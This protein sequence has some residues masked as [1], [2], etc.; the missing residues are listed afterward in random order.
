M[1]QCEYCTGAIQ[2][3]RVTVE[4]WYEGTL[5]IIKNVPVGVCG[6][7]RERYYEAATLEQL[8]AIARESESAQGRMSVPVATF[9]LS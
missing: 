6:K 4:H 2:P 1:S 8:D 5:A 7:C 3:K 9:A